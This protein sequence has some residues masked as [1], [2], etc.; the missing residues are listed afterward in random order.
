MLGGK[1]KS[2]RKRLNCWLTINSWFWSTA[3]IRLMVQWCNILKRKKR[4]NK[5][6]LAAGSHRCHNAKPKLWLF[7]LLSFS[8]SLNKY[9]TW[10]RRQKRII[11]M[12]I[13]PSPYSYSYTLLLI[14][15][16]HD[17]IPS[18]KKASFICRTDSIPFSLTNNCHTLSNSPS[19]C[20]SSQKMAF[21]NLILSSY[22]YY[23]ITYQ[24]Y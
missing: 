21:S 17:P 18:P 7:R 24:L 22:L 5:V 3:V 19:G 23:N 4:N 9:Q 13:P 16:S 8:E 10:H 11:Y 12:L 14:K 2:T 1:P 20:I 15:Y 6:V